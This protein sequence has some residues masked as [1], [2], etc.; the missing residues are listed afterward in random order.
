MLPVAMAQCSS[1]G[2]VMLY[3]SGF[4][5][6]VFH[7]ILMDQNQ[8]RYI[9]N[10]KHLNNVGPICYCEPFYIAI[11]QVS[12]LSHAATFACRG[13]RLRIDVP[14]NNNNA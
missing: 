14:D 12:L 13:C 10:K 6:N 8:S 3:T 2:M 5:D 7:S 11:H 1:D 4:V 9:S